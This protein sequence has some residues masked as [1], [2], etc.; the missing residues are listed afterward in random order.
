MVEKGKITRAAPVNLVRENEV[1]FEGKVVTLKRF[2]DD[3]KEAAEGFEC[4]IGL[5]FEGVKE[6][7]IID[8]FQ[9]EVITRRLK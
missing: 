1:V 4:G 6:G 8:A 9:E 3:V 2:K 5:G 7:D